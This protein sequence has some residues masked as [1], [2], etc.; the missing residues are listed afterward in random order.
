MAI[1]STIQ[2]NKGSEMSCKKESA[3]HTKVFQTHLN[4]Q[5]PPCPFL[6]S[7]SQ[8]NSSPW[9]APEPTRF[10][11]GKCVWR[12][13]SPT[14]PKW[15]CG[16]RAWCPAPTPL[17]QLVQHWCHCFLFT[18]GRLR[19]KESDYLGEVTPQI[20]SRPRVRPTVSELGINESRIQTLSGLVTVHVL[21]FQVM[22]LIP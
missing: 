16:P 20:N 2:H 14:V 4:V 13:R 3:F 5:S 12:L 7:R 19:P 8:V 21:F 6:P 11:L 15:I 9:G 18:Q 1:H 10:L 17:P 22:V